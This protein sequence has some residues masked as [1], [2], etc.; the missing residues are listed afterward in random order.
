MTSNAHH[1]R[2]TCRV[3]GGNSLRLFLSLGNQPL[4]NSFLKSSEEFLSEENYPLDVYV[5]T[6]CYLVQLLDVINPEVLFRHYIYVTGT[7]DTIASHNRQYAAAVVN[8]LGLGKQDLV[9]EIASN[10]GS[11][12]SCFLENGVRVLGIEPATNIAEIAR[13]NGVDTVNQFFNSQLAEQVLAEYGTA[14]AVIGNNVL[15][16]VDETLDFVQGCKTLLAPGGLVI[17]E[18]PYL[19]ELLN[20][21]EY[22]TVYHEHLC[23]FSISSL[24]SLCEAVGLSLERIDH[25]PVHGG[26]LR[27]YAGRQEDYSN[28][29]D[30][31]L[32]MV[33]E[34]ERMGLKDLGRYQRFAQLVEQ[35]RSD[36]VRLLT[37]LRREGKIIAA[38]GAPAKGNTLLNYCAI[39]TDLITYTVDKNSLKIGMYT[40]GMHLPVLPVNTLLERL[41]D[42]VLILAWN[43]A[44]E[45]MRQQAEYHQRGG[46]FIIPIPEPVVV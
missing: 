26:S 6:T 7:S 40:P 27:M 29:S 46:R 42:Y 22:D 35:T 14:R 4:A 15:A 21:L 36:L 44:D 2:A 5:C 9:V 11:L 19:G 34:E 45:I 20:H 39:G 3:C 10:D 43:F 8:Q 41:P 13:Q 18:V 31:V 16:H 33:E 12:L 37:S 30:Q 32:K 28:H 1:K 23:Y 24:V 17:F 38:Y 25:V